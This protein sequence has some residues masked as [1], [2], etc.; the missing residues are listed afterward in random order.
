M[1]A[2]QQL[3]YQFAA[4]LRD[5]RKRAPAGIE[6]RRLQLYVSLVYANIESA[7]ARAFPVLRRVSGDAEWHARIR[8]FVAR[9]R[10]ADPLFPNLAAEFLAYLARERRVRADP[11]WLRELA[12]YEW[13]EL[14]LARDMREPGDVPADPHGDLL[15]GVPV[16]SPLAWPL[17]YRYPV[18]RIAPDFLPTRPAADAVH[19]VAYRNRADEVKFMEANAVTARLLALLGRRPAPGR[20]LLGR[21]A[22][23]L[24]HPDPALVIG[25]GA[26]ILMAL[27]ARDVVLGTRIR[28][29][30]KKKT[31]R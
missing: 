18:H 26:A 7:L 25:E 15:E 27:A 5:P 19:L 10:N 6:R 16:L 13:V 11:P 20:V 29:P 8:H 28:N 2:F 17:A 14:A 3:Q 9:H 22:R 23:E 1:K 4:H 30:R 21:I 24:G 31:R 12:H